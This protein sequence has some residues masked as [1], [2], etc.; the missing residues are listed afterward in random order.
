MFLQ[1]YKNAAIFS[2]ALR[3]T[4]YIKYL[5]LIVAKNVKLLYRRLFLTYPSKK[6]ILKSLGLKLLIKIYRYF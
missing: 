5:I 4:K 2:P 3:T 6:F 1:G